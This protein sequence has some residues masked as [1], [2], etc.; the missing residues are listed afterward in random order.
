MA[1]EE[2]TRRKGGT[3]EKDLK[4]GCREAFPRFLALEQS[5]CCSRGLSLVE[6]LQAE[7]DRPPVGDS[8]V[9]DSTVQGVT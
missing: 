4:A 6:D 1:P 8:I 9:V 2:G 5:A 3:A 7:A